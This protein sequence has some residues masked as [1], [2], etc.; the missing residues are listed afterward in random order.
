MLCYLHTPD[1]PVNDLKAALGAKWGLKELGSPHGFHILLDIPDSSRDFMRLFWPFPFVPCHQA[2]S[3]SVCRNW[4]YDGEL[5]ASNIL[6]RVRVREDT[7]RGFGRLHTLNA[8]HSG[9]SQ[10]ATRLRCNKWA[11]QDT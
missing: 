5:I 7:H 4:S 3:P 9:S 10:L 1:P 6:A 8:A 11:E 2:S